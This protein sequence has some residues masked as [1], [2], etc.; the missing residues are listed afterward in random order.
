M[1][2]ILVYLLQI[3]IYIIHKVNKMIKSIDPSPNLPNLYVE[4][5]I[6]AKPVPNSPTSGITNIERIY[7]SN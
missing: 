2:I 3:N 6:G 5:Y 4:I 1:Q 7:N